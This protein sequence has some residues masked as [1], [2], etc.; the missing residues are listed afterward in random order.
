MRASGFVFLVLLSTLDLAAPRIAL[1]ADSGSIPQKIAQSVHLNTA[2]QVKVS[3][4]TNNASAQSPVTFRASATSPSCSKGIHAMRIYTA[5]HVKAYTVK[6]NQLRTSLSLAPGTYHTVVQAWDNCGQVGKTPVTVT[7]AG[8]SS[9]NHYLYVME[10]KGVSGWVLN[11]TSG[12]LSPTGQGVV[13]AHADPYRAAS[14]KSGTHLYVANVTSNDISAYIINRK[15]GYLTRAPGSPYAVGRTAS[16][17][18]VHPS[19]KFV[20]VTRD[21]DAPGDG[22]AAFSVNANGSL[23]AVPGSPFSTQ[24]NPESL[25]VDASGKYLYV[26]DSAYSGYI[27]A[28]S[29]NQVNGALTPLAGSPFAI[30]PAYGCAASYAADIAEDV[31]GRHIYTADS[32][33]NAISAY[34]MGAKTGT[35]T[36]VAGSAFPDYPCVDPMVAFN[37]DT[38]TVLP[39]GKFLYAGNGL[40]QTISTYS[41]HST[42]GL[43]FVHETAQCF[44]GVGSG[45]ILRSDPTGKFLYTVGVSG[46]NCSG[47]RAIVGFAVNPATG[48]LSV[49]KGSPTLDSYPSGAV[50]GAIVV[51]P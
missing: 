9:S 40:A 17:V 22:I 27:D 21:N 48:T 3:S 14:D 15:N 24:N 26:A 45:P 16:A 42:G 50:G 44:N 19:G 25:T 8:L 41:V 10:G 28:F 47:S 36:Q 23:T 12:A 2:P 1:A 31:V 11:P 34:S 18:A 43:S 38:L 30:T 32:F 29:I 5:A 13:P 20:Y 35:L 33:D 49:A 51:V 37:P 4:P 7:I 39:S 46:K 6:G